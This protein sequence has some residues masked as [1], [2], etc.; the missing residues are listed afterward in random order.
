[1]SSVGYMVMIDSLCEGSVP[2]LLDGDGKPWVFATRREAEL[3]I[4]DLLELRLGEFHEGLRDCEDAVTVEEYVV[5]VRIDGSD[6]RPVV[7][8]SG[9]PVVLAPSSSGPCRVP[10]AE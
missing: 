2:S 4:I 7:E 8:A 3:E 5:E 1:M 10:S 6:Q 9:L